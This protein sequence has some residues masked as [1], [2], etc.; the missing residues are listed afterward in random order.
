MILTTIELLW[1]R[2]GTKLAVIDFGSKLYLRLCTGIYTT[3]K[4][5]GKPICKTLYSKFDIM[6]YFLY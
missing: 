2:S 3:L 6:I 4:W 1:S 5:K